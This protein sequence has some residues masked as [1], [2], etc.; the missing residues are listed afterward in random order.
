LCIN[1][2]NKIYKKT[3]PNKDI[4]QVPNFEDFQLIKKYKVNR[5]Y[6]TYIG[7]VE[8][9]KGIE[10]LIKSFFLVVKVKPEEKLQIIGSGTYLNYLKKLSLKLNLKK[11]IIFR[12]YIE[13]NKLDKYYQM[14]KAV[15]IPSIILENITLVG[16]EAIK[17]KTFIIASNIG[18][19]PDLIK[20]NN[21]ILF[22]PNNINQ[23]AKI[24][25]DEKKFKN[26]YD[27]IKDYKMYSKE[28]K[29]ARLMEVYNQKINE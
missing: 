5:K 24:M 21:G 26:N 28:Y 20:N 3:F 13:N 29:Y 19:I 2:I 17:N 4:I 1:N 23:L 18:G 10:M 14:S 12:G 16:I 11:N 6:F 7:R 9:E 15:I 22:E 25:L 8:K 27:N